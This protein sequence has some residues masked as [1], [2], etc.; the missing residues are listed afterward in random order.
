L[1]TRKLQVVVLALFL[2]FSPRVSKADGEWFGAPFWIAAGCVGIVTAW[3]RSGKPTSAYRILLNNTEATKDSADQLLELVLKLHKIVPKERRAIFA[4][5]REAKDSQQLETELLWHIEHFGRAKAGGLSFSRWFE[6]A[7]LGDPKAVWE[8]ELVPAGWTA[9]AHFGSLK[10]F[11]RTGSDDAYA[12][13]D[14]EQ[15]RIYFRM[16]PADNAI[17]IL[18]AVRVVYRI[19]AL[20]LMDKNSYKIRRWLSANLPTMPGLDATLQGNGRLGTRLGTNSLGEDM[21]FS[22]SEF[23]QRD[24]KYL[25]GTIPSRL[26]AGLQIPLLSQ[27]SGLFIS[28][29]ARQHADLYTYKNY[30]NLIGRYRALRSSRWDSVANHDSDFSLNSLM[31]SNALQEMGGETLPPHAEF[32]LAKTLEEIIE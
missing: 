4:M 17:P 19:Q 5:V 25:L 13:I 7:G 28:T 32:I 27:V 29:L 1:L 22:E 24:A 3:V 23:E 12:Y 9:K 20:E 6:S 21:L 31:A 15:K 11:S 8:N 16:L 18:E 2:S 30:L 10:K 26:Q 14:M